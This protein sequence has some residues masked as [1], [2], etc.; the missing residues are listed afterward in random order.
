MKNNKHFTI[1]TSVIYMI[2]VL[3]I[4]LFFTNSTTFAQAGKVNFSGT[5]TFNESKSTQ[6]QG[7]FRMAPSLMTII[8][9]GNNLTV[10][11]TSK[12]R[13]GEDVKSTS[14]FS[15]DGK[16]CVNT[17][18]GTNTRKSLVTWATDGKTLNFSHVMNF[19]RN[20][21][22]TEFKST[23]SWKI[24]DADKTLSVETIFNGPNG[25]IKSTNIYNKK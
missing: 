3:V 6:S 14:K 8:Q 24:N 16:E 7:G 17:V 18:F 10:D 9:D 1:K 21:Q 15:L 12:N 22:T 20:G 2:A 25:E 13:D 11:R 23:E 4:I 19:E 5:W